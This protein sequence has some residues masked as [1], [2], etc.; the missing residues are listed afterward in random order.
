M[1]I[2]IVISFCVLLGNLGYS[3]VGV[4]TSNPQ[5]ELHVA[6]S[7]STIRVEGLNSTNNP[8]NTGART[9]PVHVDSDGDLIVPSSPAGAEILFSSDNLLISGVRVSTQ[10]GG[11]VNDS[12]IYTTSFTLTQPA[13]VLISYSMTL[14]F[15][16][17]DLNGNKNPLNNDEKPRVAA[18]YLRM[19]NGTIA[20]SNIIGMS[21]QS[22]TGNDDGGFIATGFT[23]NNA[24]EHILLP[25]GT[26]SVHIFGSVFANSNNNN[27]NDAFSAD[28][29][30]SA[31]DY[32]RI[33]AI[34]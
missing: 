34:Y 6:G 32:L 15:F 26:H 23:Y 4:G 30:G 16:E 31:F 3:Q 18:N 22:Y 12:Q 9:Q 17:Y 10:S 5:Q 28:F 21:G 1:R 11:N 19:G 27:T 2:F 13:I 33:T 24:T 14:E 20:T 7:S 29:G 8:N 25:A